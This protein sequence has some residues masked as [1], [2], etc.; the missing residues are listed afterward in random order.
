MASFFALSCAVLGEE[1][2]HVAALEQELGHLHHG[3]S[4]FRPLGMGLDEPFELVLGVPEQ[5]LAAD[6]VRPTRL[7]D[8]EPGLLVVEP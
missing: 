3:V 7:V 5:L 2:G 6:Q 8:Q 1:R 4:G